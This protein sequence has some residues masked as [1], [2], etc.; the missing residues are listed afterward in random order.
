MRKYSP[1]EIIFLQK[2]V[3]G[4]SFLEVSIL[5]N[6]HFGTC[7]R[8]TEIHAACKSR[9]ITNGRDARFWTGH[10]SWNKGRKG[11]HCSPA[12]E[13]KKGNKPFNY[14]PEGSERINTEG[15]VDIKIAEPN[16]WK[17]KHRSIWEK[18]NGP[19]PKGSVIIFGD[20]NKMNLTLDNLVVVSRAELAVMNSLG[21]IYEDAEFT[22]TGKL[23][24]DIKIGIADRKK[25]S[26]HRS[27]KQRIKTKR[28]EAN[29]WK[30]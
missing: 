12:T 1:E 26:R 29:A 21:L 30:N 6:K 23:I 25:E 18:A 17:A 24:A 8:E 16:K 5:F 3:P 28:R 27:A 2:I 11:I 19:V 13:F 7:L 10:N 14:M 15:Y 22:K 9:G 20:G 4:R